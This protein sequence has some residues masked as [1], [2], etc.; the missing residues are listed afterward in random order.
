MHLVM[1]ALR[2]PVAR[3]LLEAL[4]ASDDA[5]ETLRR[6]GD[7]HEAILDAVTAG[8]GERA[9]QLVERHIRRFYDTLDRTG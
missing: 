5:P 3:H 7:E 6:L 8:D 4:R 9:A 1:M 2:D